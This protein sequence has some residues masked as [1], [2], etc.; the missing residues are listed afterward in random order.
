MSYYSELSAL[1]HQVRLA[2][3]AKDIAAFR[4]ATLPPSRKRIGLL[5]DKLKQ[6]LS[7]SEGLHEALHGLPEQRGEF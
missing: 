7:E 4:E 1:R 2:R 3:Q 6:S 5:Y